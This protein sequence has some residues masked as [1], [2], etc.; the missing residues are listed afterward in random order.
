M[1]Q[2]FNKIIDA[3]TDKIINDSVIKNKIEKNILIPVIQKGYIHI[4]PYLLN[5]LYM[6][7]IIVLLLLIII[8]L[9]FLK[10]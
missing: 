8:I 6:Y 3:C 4:R 7:S 1:S 9:L 5:I 10:K 2:I